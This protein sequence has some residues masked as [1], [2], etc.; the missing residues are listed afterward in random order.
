MEDGDEVS[1][2]VVA[3]RWRMHVR[4]VALNMSVLLCSDLGHKI[5]SFPPQNAEESVNDLNISLNSL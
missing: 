2:W 5:A 1:V 3:A 4:I